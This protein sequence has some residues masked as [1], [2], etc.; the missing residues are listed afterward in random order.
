[1]DDRLRDPLQLSPSARGQASHILIR[2][3]GTNR[4]F[5]SLRSSGRPHQRL[6]PCSGAE[7]STVVQ[8][9]SARYVTLGEWFV[10]DIRDV[11]AERSWTEQAACAGE[12]GWWLNEGANPH[13][14]DR[15]TGSATELLKLL[16]CAAC[17]VRAPCL[18]T[19]L[20]PPPV[21]FFVDTE[22]HTGAQLRGSAARPRQWGTWGGTDERTRRQ[23]EG[24][25][26]Q[27]RVDLLE[28]TL[29]ERIAIRTAAW[30]ESLRRRRARHSGVSERDRRL[31]ALLGPVGR[32][33]L[34]GL[35]GPGRGHRG[36][37]ARYAAEH[38]CSRD[39]AWR[40]LRVSAPAS[41]HFVSAK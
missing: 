30:S 41:A 15:N 1:M 26:L 29:P 31:E 9:R 7:P 2:D 13:S 16:I 38:G 20:E 25:P 21:P 17:P 40:R 22:A 8:S 32:F 28:A 14:P 3:V 11:L 19:S 34:G 23:T 4:G 27:E 12:D 33:Y 10:P 5:S 36:P 39:T 24:L 35:P 37:I 6:T 18:R